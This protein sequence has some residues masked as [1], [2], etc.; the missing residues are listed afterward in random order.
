MIIVYFACLV[1]CR[2]C[3]YLFKNRISAAVHELL[4]MPSSDIFYLAELGVDLMCHC[5]L[6]GHNSDWQLYMKF[7]NVLNQI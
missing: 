7:N 3:M 1:F 4:Q 2:K 5:L 6:N